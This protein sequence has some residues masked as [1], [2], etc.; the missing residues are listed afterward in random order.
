MRLGILFK[1]SRNLGKLL[2]LGG[3][4]FCLCLAGCGKDGI[5]TPVPTS[6]PSYN[7][8]IS[9]STSGSIT[10]NGVLLPAQQVR[11]SFGVGGYIESIAVEVGEGVQ[12]GQTLARL[13]TIDLE[14]AVGQAELDLHR[15]QVGLSQTELSLRQLQ[16]PPD[17]TDIRQAEHAVDQAGA[18]LKAAQLDLA[19]VLDSTLLNETLEDAERVYEDMR[20]KYGA[21]LEMYESG[22]EPDYWF[23]DQAKQR[24]DDTKLNLDRIRQQGNAQLQEARNAVQHAEQMVQETQ[25]ALEELL[26]EADPLDV[27]AAQKEIEAATVE[28]EAAELALAAA[29]A[30]LEQAALQA[31]FDGVV[32]AVP[33]SLGEWAAPGAT[34]VELLDVSRWRIETKNVGELQIARVRVGQE[35]RVRVNAFRDETLHGHVVTISP[36]AVVQQGD[37]T[38]TLMIELEPT[39]LNLQAGMTAQ[40][41]ILTE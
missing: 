34:V 10:A 2:L 8:P 3:L 28:V 6:A 14:R 20:H 40:V 17:E 1:G 23:V 22:E 26:E 18:T 7:D 32:S 11:L 35:V 24:L 41:E 4:A 39:D 27:E 13:E 38:Y 12:A 37:T 29:Q 16:E 25:D 19:A 21:R 30:D 36:V 33:V 5:S 15:A 31:P 9:G